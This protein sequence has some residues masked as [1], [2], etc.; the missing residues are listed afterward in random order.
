MHKKVVYFDNASTTPLKEEVFQAMLPYFKD[1]FGNP[2]NLYGM[3]RKAKQAIN[4]AT[5]KISS[6][7]NC[8]PEEFIYTGSATEADNLA[9]AGTARANK[10]YGNRIIISEVEHKGILSVCEQLKKEGF[11]IVQLPVNK[12]GLVSLEALK[13][14]LNEKTILVSIT[15]A[16][17]ETGTIQPIREI[18]RIIKSRGETSR[19]RLEADLAK[20]PLGRP[21][22]HTDASQAATY[23]DI[24]VEELG[25]DLLTLS[26][27][28]MGGPKGIGGLYIKRGTNIEPIIYGG[29]QQGHLR[30]GTENV[31]AIAGFGVAFGEASPRG[32][33]SKIATGKASKLRDRLERGI[34]KLIPKVRLN[35]HKT[36][37]LPN[38]LNVSI[39]DIEGEALLLHLDEL[40]IIVNTGSACNAENLKPSYVLTAMGNPYEFVHGS[41][42]FTLGENNTIKDVD[43]VLKHLPNIV[44]KLRA[45]SPL[46]LEASPRG[47]AS[48]NHVKKC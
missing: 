43:Y 36:K 8:L 34:F 31:P 11:E 42:R 13:K 25:V 29:G 33:F 12:D 3:G 2:S 26:A 14:A 28:K 20:S 40:G 19:P 21:R 41:I 27:H 7:L 44:K 45:I 48:K 9:I 18:V 46:N 37:R 10:K 39:L 35:G 1:E 38:F 16:D 15:M 5:F 4:E 24:N 32:R 23:L 47:E 17:S 22:F 6:A 30:S